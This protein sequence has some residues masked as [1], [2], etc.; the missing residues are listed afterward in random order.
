MLICPNDL[1]LSVTACV[2]GGLAFVTENMRCKMQP[3]KLILNLSSCVNKYCSKAEQELEAHVD[4][5]D[6]IN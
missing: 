6:K 2:T 1:G 3:F 5:P 4:F